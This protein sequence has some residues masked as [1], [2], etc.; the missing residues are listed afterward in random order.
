[1]NV[2]G[3]YRLLDLIETAFAEARLVQR[4][5]PKEVLPQ[6]LGGPDSESSTLLGLHAVADRNDGVQAVKREGFIGRSN[7][8][9]LHITFSVQFTLGKNVV[10]VLGHDGALATE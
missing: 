9:I 4:V 8:Q 6:G 7:V 1:M 2:C 10:H 5:S 3:V